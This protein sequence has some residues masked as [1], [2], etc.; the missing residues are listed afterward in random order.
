MH[1]AS[2]KPHSKNDAAMGRRGDAEMRRSAVVNIRS[3]KEL[4][5]Y[6]GAMEAAMRIFER[7]ASGSDA[8]SIHRASPLLRCSI[9]IYG[10]KHSF[11][12]T[13]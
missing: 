8:G 1:C 10:Y 6:Q 3:Y 9:S 12:G 13:C 11:F 5:V 4:R 2:G 7:N